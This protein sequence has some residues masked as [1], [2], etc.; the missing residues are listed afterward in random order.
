VRVLAGDVEALGVVEDLWV[1]VGA[2]EEQN[3]RFA[4]LDRVTLDIDVGIGRPQG[5]LHG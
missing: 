2:P 3:H 4:L 1:A 5:H